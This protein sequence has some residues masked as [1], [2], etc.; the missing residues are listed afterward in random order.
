MTEPHTESLL[1]DVAPPPTPV[2][3]LLHLADQYTQHNDALDLLPR[4]RP[5]STGCP[6]CLRATS[7]HRHPVRHQGDPE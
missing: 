6:R 3:R 4:R 1:F 2:E 5:A 7:G